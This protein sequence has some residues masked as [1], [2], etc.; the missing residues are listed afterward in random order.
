MKTVCE[1]AVYAYDI[2]QA[3]C[4]RLYSLA[5]HTGCML[6]VLMLHVLMLYVLKLPVRQFR[7]P[8]IQLLEI[9]KTG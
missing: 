2:L 3:C 8:W 9:Y 6:L 5:L 4:C 7:T 1:A